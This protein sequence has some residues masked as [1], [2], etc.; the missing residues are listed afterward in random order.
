VTPIPLKLPSWAWDICWLDCDQP[1]TRIAYLDLEICLCPPHAIVL[2]D[3]LWGTSL[4]GAPLPAGSR[5][6]A[7][8]WRAA[9]QA[10]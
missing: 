10:A 6:A 2:D 1:G 8:P 4:D 9:E 7:W 3:G 5:A